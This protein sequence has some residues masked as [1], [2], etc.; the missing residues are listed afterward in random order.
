[1]NERDTIRTMVAGTVD[2][3][4]VTN[5]EAWLSTVAPVQ[6]PFVWGQLAGGHSNLTYSIR[7]GAGRELVIRRPPMGQ[8]LPK[9]HDMER[10]YRIIE[11]LWPTDVPV[12]QPVA[13]CDDRAV[14]ETHFYVM[15]RM[16]GKALHSA[17]SVTGWLGL[18][19]R[20][21]AADEI[22]K[23]LA[24]LHRIEPDAVG[25]GDLGRPT[26]YA[27][28]QIRTWH[29][30]WE[31]QVE[32]AGYDDSRSHE[33][34]AVLLARM[35]ADGATR[36]VHGDFGPHNSLFRRSGEI[37]AVLDW[38]I[39]TLGEPLADL[40]YVVNAWVGPNDELVDLRSPPT[41]L[42]GFPDR[43][44]MIDRYVELTG[45]NVSNLTYYRVFSFWR[46][47]CIL[48]GVYGRYRTGQKN[49]TGVD[50]DGIRARISVLLDAA[51]ELAEKA[52][53]R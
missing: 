45:S 19:A 18:P 33:L 20:R 15:D 23:V 53:S 28:R 16:I 10:E 27:A 2:G 17:S 41:H 6:P 3:F 26:G 36:V 12:P 8:L 24:A 32:N 37:S 9:A 25:L 46:R 30:S 51:V 34:H 31:S 1:M 43:Q 21:R 38:E 49:S 35:P 14:A 29:S 5:V 42:P 40:A 11:A 39:A 7:D 50:I 13:Y 52:L 22:V 4:D 44:Q 47:A 48:Q